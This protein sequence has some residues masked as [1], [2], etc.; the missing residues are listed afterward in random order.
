V[1]RSFR[2]ESSLLPVFPWRC[3]L[4]VWKGF[5]D[6]VDVTRKGF[7]SSSGAL[8][9]GQRGTNWEL[10]FNQCRLHHGMQVLQVCDF[11][12]FSSPPAFPPCYCPLYLSVSGKADDLWKILQFPAWFPGIRRQLLRRSTRPLHS[13]RAALAL[14]AISATAS[15]Q[16]RRAGDPKSGLETSSQESVETAIMI[17]TSMR[18]DG[19]CTWP[20]GSS[21][22]PSGR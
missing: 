17:L 8:P 1:S 7:S 11:C 9:M 4:L 16:A 13:G 20:L 15:R 21:H 18:V 22:L 5:R 14:A 10:G 2:Y 3:V 19:C 6:R 12:A